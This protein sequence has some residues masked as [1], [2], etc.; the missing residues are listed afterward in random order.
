MSAA[1]YSYIVRESQEVTK[2]DKDKDMPY[3]IIVRHIF[4]QQF[5]VIKRS[6]LGQQPSLF[7]LYIDGKSDVSCF[8]DNSH[9]DMVA[10]ESEMRC[11]CVCDSS[12]LSG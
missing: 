12:L 10:E 6:I 7:T 5:L 2:I 3:M 8:Y 9:D 1:R 11:V 4:L